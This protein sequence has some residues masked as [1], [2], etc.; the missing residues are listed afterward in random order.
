MY[1]VQTT[2]KRH[3]IVK[4]LSVILSIGV[5]LS[6]TVL[7]SGCIGCSSDSSGNSYTQAEYERAKRAVIQANDNYYR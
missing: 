6:F 7:S 4:I 3:P 1:P 5:L 2:K